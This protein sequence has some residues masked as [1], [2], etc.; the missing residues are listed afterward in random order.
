M[1][2]IKLSNASRSLAEYARE[3]DDDVLVLTERDK[4][5]AAIVPLT[6]VDRESLALSA[7]PEFLELIAR[8]RREFQAGKKVSLEQVKRAMLGRSGTNKPR[9]RHT[10]SRRKVA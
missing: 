1:K 7:H 2:T 10:V 9:R 3:L 4:P 8:S 5:L 6:N